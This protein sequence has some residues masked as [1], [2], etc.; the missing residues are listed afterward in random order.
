M[1]LLSVAVD[2]DTVL[3]A[4]WRPAAL[5]GLAACHVKSETAGEHCHGPTHRAV[6]TA[7]AFI[8]KLN[9]KNCP[10]ALL[11]SVAKSTI[12]FC[13][14]WTDCCLTFPCF[15]LQTDILQSC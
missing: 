15:I 1:S 8:G 3:L 10:R 4:V 11:C 7:V 6:L 14:C 2:G 5:L 13:N 12:V 9:K